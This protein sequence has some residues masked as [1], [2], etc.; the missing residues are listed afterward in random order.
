MLQRFYL[1]LKIRII[2]WYDIAWTSYRN[3]IEMT[4]GS[5]KLD[6]DY[7][8]IKYEPSPSCVAFKRPVDGLVY[9]GPAFAHYC[10]A[11]WI[12]WTAWRG[13]WLHCSRRPWTTQSTCVWL[14]DV[15]RLSPRLFYATDSQSDS[16]SSIWRAR[17]AS[18]LLML[19]WHFQLITSLARWHCSLCHPS[20][21]R[22]TGI[23]LR[24]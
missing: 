9:F 24:W 15:S 20:N 2:V 7:P 4:A 3:L 17:S 1:V 16:Y 19:F 6:K 22:N 12:E 13:G 21:R 11:F 10:F 18:W 8:T 14:S 23:M 5:S